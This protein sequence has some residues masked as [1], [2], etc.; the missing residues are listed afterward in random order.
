MQ[1][2]PEYN[3]RFFQN[4]GVVP[5]SVQKP[6]P[7]IWMACSRRESILRAVR[8]GLGALV[9]RFVEASQANVWCDEYYEIIKSQ[10]CVPIGR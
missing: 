3:G 1:P 5:K 10:N 8:H 2:Y 6:D 4:A 7:P 9:F